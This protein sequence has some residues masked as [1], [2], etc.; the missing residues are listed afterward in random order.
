MN[1]A[2]STRVVSIV[3]G[4][5]MIVAAALKLASPAKALGAVAYA[6]RPVV[7]V[8]PLVGAG[9]VFVLI[10][11]ECVLGVALLLSRSRG[12]RWIAGAVFVGF[13]LV[14]VTRFSDRGAPPC[15]CLGGL[16]QSDGPWHVWVD[17]TRNMFFALALLLTLGRDCRANSGKAERASPGA[18]GAQRAFTMVEMLVTIA[19]VAV[20]VVITVPILRNS[21]MS[22]RVVK[23]MAAQK[24]IVAAVQVYGQSYGDYFPHF[25]PLDGLQG[26]VIIRGTTVMQGYFRAHLSLWLAAVGPDDEALIEL[27]IWPPGS[28]NKVGASAAEAGLFYSVYYMTATAAADPALFTDPVANSPDPS[29]LR[30][31]RWEEMTFPSKKGLFLDFALNST[32]SR[33][34]RVVAS[35][36]DGSVAE[37]AGRSSPLPIVALPGDG[38]QTIVISTRN[39]IRGVDR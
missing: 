10:V 16:L 24:Q 4:M 15:G 32:G 39:G 34:D 8:G 21:K 27:A 36:G 22:T 23:S 17:A 9:L 12:V 14:L 5:F 29:L 25:E 19:V 33:E 2:L 37:L 18:E 1:V 11:G 3:T 35:F 30:G 28:R 6:I 20:L 38:P 13:G 31:V 7:G 26:P